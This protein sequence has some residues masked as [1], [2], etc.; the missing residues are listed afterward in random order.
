MD[1]LHSNE[2]NEQQQYCSSG[3][4]CRRLVIATEIRVRTQYHSYRLPRITAQF[5]VCL[6]FC[7]S[8]KKEIL[9]T[10]E[11]AHNFCDCCLS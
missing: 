8:T 11:A 1:T 9:V 4:S 2:P 5:E 7:D 3:A 6:P 10:L